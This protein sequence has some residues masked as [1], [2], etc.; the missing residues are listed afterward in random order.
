MEI[1]SACLSLQTTE[2][3]SHWAKEA[4]ITV[5]WEKKPEGV[6]SRTQKKGLNIKPWGTL[7]V[8]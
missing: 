7:S 8:C 1:L 5:C 4:D 2:H 3:Q 6:A